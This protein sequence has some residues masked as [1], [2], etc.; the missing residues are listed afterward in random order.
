M[1]GKTSM[2]TKKYS[3]RRLLW[4]QE[5]ERTEKVTEIYNHLETQM[6]Q[7]SQNEIILGE[8][9]SAKLELTH[10]TGNPGKLGPAKADIRF[11][12]RVNRNKPSEK[13]AIDYI[14]TMPEIE[15]SSKTW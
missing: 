4:P 2:Q 5:K 6:N 1:L 7:P 10:S 8:D 9:F 12:T 13:S 3:N 14:L 11:W 15:K